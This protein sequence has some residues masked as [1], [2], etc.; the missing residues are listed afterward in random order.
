M[1]T[2]GLLWSSEVPKLPYTELTWLTFQIAKLIDHESPRGC[3]LI[4]DK[5]RFPHIL[6]GLGQGA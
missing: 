6:D 5:V 1:F 2:E 3:Q 4:T